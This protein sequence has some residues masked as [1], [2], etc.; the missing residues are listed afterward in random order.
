MLVDV[1]LC[2]AHCV[3]EQHSSYLKSLT[4]PPGVSSHHF[5]DNM[6]FTAGSLRIEEPPKVCGY[7]FETWNFS[8]LF[9]IHSS[10]NGSCCNSISS[11]IT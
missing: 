4:L 1:D 3:C 11:V 6:Q 10:G 8:H 7:V 9:V 2:T 5:F